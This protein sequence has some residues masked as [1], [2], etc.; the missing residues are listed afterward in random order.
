MFFDSSVFLFLI[1]LE[2]HLNVFSQTNGGAIIKASPVG[3]ILT[4]AS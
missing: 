1:Y 3:F 4:P 2:F